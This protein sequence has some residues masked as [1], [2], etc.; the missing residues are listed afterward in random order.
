M[1]VRRCIDFLLYDWL[2]VGGLTTRPRFA[3]HSRGTFDAVL[4]LCERLAR[5]KF[6][7]VNRAADVEEPWFDG[8]RCTCPPAASPRRGLCR[9]RHA[10]RRARHGGRRHAAALCRRDGGQQLLRDGQRRAVGCG[11]LTAANAGLLMAHGS[12]RQKQAFAHPALAG[13]CFGTMCLSEPQAGSSL[14]DITR[15]RCP[16]ATASQPTRWGPANRLHGTRCGSPTAST[17]WPRTSCTWC[18][19]RFPAADG[20]LVPGTRGISLFVVPKWLVDADGTPTGER[21]DVALAGLNHK[22]GYRGIPN[23][24]LNFGEGR[25]PVRGAAGALGWLVGRPGDGLRCM[26]HMMNEARIGV[27]LGATMLGMAGY[28]ASLAYARERPQGR[29]P[30]CPRQ[31]PGASRRCRSS[32]MPTSSACCWRRRVI[33]RARSRWRC[34]ARGWSTSSTPARPTP[35]PRPARC[36][37]C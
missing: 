30:R 35:R 11:M 14:S 20:S 22:L 17:S 27:G 9:Q 21:N 23:T 8:E 31:G 26:F 5:D 3:D 16:T 4:D 25:H 29:A 18:S 32:A 19:R 33:A 15:A 10:R 24:L 2:D 28:E 34:T 1:T 13:R 7:P 6:A 12:A 36:W 37:S